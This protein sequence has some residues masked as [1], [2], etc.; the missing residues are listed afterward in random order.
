M[1]KRTLCLISLFVLVPLCAHITFIA[2]AQSKAQNQ[3]LL[4]STDQ[5]QLASPQ[6]TTN[7]TGTKRRETSITGRLI[8]DSGQPIPNA[9]LH[10]WRV[11]S[12]NLSRSIGT[13]E[14]GRFRADDLVPGVYSVSPY[15]PGYVAE[16]DLLDRQFY[17]PGETVTLRMIKGAVVTGTVTNSSG[18]PIVAARVSAVRVRDAEGRPIVR[19]GSSGNPRQ[20]DD[21]GV[22]RLYGLQSGSYL[23]VVSGG[24]AS[25]YNTSGFDG[26]APTYYPSTT[27][28]A[29]AEV[30]VHTGDEISGIDI[31][32]RGE[33]GHIVS[34]TLSGSLGSD[35]KSRSVSVFLSQAASGALESATY[36]PLRGDERG[37]AL[38]GVP[39]GEY[40]LAATG[41]TGTEDAAASPPRHIA[42]KGSDVTGLEIILSPL[43][44]IAGRVILETL[45]DVQRN[46]DCK[47]KRGEHLD[48]TVIVARRDEKP[49]A[50]DQ[51]SISFIT[52]T[53]DATPDEKGEFKI[54]GLMAGR[55]RIETRLPSEDWFVSS[56]T[57][58]EPGATKQ[59]TDLVSGGM[60]ISSGHRAVGLTVA[61]AEGAAGL[62]GKVV[63][64]SQGGALPTRLRVH[65]V[66]AEADSAD[67]GLRYVEAAVDNDGAFSVNNL[68]PGRYFLLARAVTDEEFME[69]TPRPM[70]W[71]AASR[72]KLR[73]DA[74][75]ADIAIELRR[76]LRVTDYVFKY[77]PPSGAKKRAP[78]AKQ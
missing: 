24:N 20:T 60:A 4:F 7:Q 15:V 6:S 26:D 10:V 37:F 32:Y 44:S 21:R 36:I 17:R 77:S 28:D 46:G 34:G 18:E 53:A 45:T 75:A 29:A 31:R 51:S 54:S 62:R 72:A 55:Y 57:V 13:D 38:Y 66:P 30:T 22:Y 50:K 58:P 11:G 61:L 43:G 70:A 67:A 23:I 40:E 49:G 78:G 2:T 69:R 25:F 42:V 41:G 47:A 64:A 71:E 12:A 16:T 33:R 63:A 9:A 27:R 59:Q 35:P 8:N 5:S 74:E 48:E 56:I 65:L 73:R 3:T 14:D 76:C 68:A 52:P 19:A 1:T 39:D